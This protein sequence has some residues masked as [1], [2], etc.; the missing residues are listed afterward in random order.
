LKHFDDKGTSW[1]NKKKTT[2]RRCIASWSR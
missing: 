1:Q 2:R